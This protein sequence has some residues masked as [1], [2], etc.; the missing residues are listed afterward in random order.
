MIDLSVTVRDLEP[1]PHFCWQLSPSIRYPSL[2][3]PPLPYSVVYPGGTDALQD[4]LFVRDFFLS[5]FLSIYNRE[6]ERDKKREIKR[7]IEREQQQ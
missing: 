2:D 1:D 4:A 3:P 6:R 5:F 7:W